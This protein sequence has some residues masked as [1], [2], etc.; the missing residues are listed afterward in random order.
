MS[1]GEDLVKLLA[2]EKSQKILEKIARQISKDDDTL[3]KNIAMTAMTG[4][5]AESSKELLA[6]IIVKAVKQVGNDIGNVKLEKRKGEGNKDLSPSAKKTNNKEAKPDKA[7][8]QKP[9]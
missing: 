9:G 8:E 3:L 5:G 6:D 4:K 7:S 1:T 2:A